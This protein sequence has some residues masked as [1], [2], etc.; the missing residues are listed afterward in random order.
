VQTGKARPRP[1]V[2]MDTPG[3][4]FWRSTLKLFK[5]NF[6][7]G[8]LISPGDLELVRHFQS[9]DAAVEEIR[10]FYRNYH[11]SRFFKDHYLIRLR[12]DL[13]PQI[14]D[15]LNRDFRGLLSHGRFEILTDRS[16]DDV[17]D[18]ALHRLVFCFDR[19]SYHRLRQLIDFLNQL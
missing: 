14:L 6:E 15:K 4:S 9:A 13:S 2:L 18:A 11:S 8:G 7:G 3:S 12:K 17:K 1:I 10:G 16:G 5:R 19:S